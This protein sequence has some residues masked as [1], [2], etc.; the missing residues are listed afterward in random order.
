MKKVLSLLLVTLLLV[1][2]VPAFAT[3]TDAANDDYKIIALFDSDDVTGT[4]MTNVFNFW[5]NYDANARANASSTNVRLS[6]YSAQMGPLG[7]GGYQ[8][9]HMLCFGDE[10]VDRTGY[11]YINFVIYSNTAITLPSYLVDA[12]GATGMLK[13]SGSNSGWFSLNQGWNVVTLGL[14]RRQNTDPNKADFAFADNTTI[15]EL[16]I[17]V[18]SDSLVIPTGVDLL[19]EGTKVKQ[20]P[21]FSTACIYFDAIYLSKAAPTAPA[22]TGTSIANGATG[23]SRNLDKYVVTFDSAMN[24]KS[25]T[26]ET[27]T[28]KETATGTPV[29]VKSVTANGDKA[30]IAFDAGTLAA[31]TEYTVTVSGN[32][33]NAYGVSL[34]ADAAYT[35]TTSPYAVTGIYANENV[36]MN[37]GGARNRVRT[38]GIN[39]T[40]NVAKV[41]YM[42]DGVEAATKTAAPFTWDMPLDAVASHSLSAVVYDAADAAYEADGVNFKVMYESPVAYKESGF[43]G[44]VGE[45]IPTGSPNIFTYYQSDRGTITYA[46]DPAGVKEGTV[47]KAVKTYAENK[48]FAFGLNVPIDASRI[49]QIDVDIYVT[50]PSDVRMRIDKH[51][52]YAE[53]STCIAVYDLYNNNDKPAFKSGANWNHVTVLMDFKAPRY[54][55]YINGAFHRGG[56]LHENYLTPANFG[57]I[58][59]S[60]SPYYLDDLKIQTIDELTASDAMLDAATFTA[61]EDGWDADVTIANFAN[62]AKEYTVLTAVYDA[63]GNVIAVDKQVV[64]APAD[65]ISTTEYTVAKTRGDKTGAK[66]RAFVW[67]SVEGVLTLRPIAEIK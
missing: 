57:L 61:T 33:N 1:A 5:N 23:I 21:N 38:V 14:N 24:A 3:G 44:T 58:F 6:D 4:K 12:T 59:A 8:Y 46:E 15:K 16:N 28:V 37:I 55:I 29:T 39:T 45:A 56:V 50:N 49:V 11:D 66:V 64:N 51:S 47:L 65:E 18:A 22:V 41:V 34:G 35:F 10:G 48:D 26:A 7:T 2:A 32:V 54:E 20:Q 67:E 42:L 9:Y 62:I 63:S 36:L 27:L 43:E 31:G 19:N 25:F 60:K 30:T 40:E 13:D 52:V 53:T 17:V